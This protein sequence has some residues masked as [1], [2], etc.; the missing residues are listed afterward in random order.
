MFKQ[1]DYSDLINKNKYQVFLFKSKAFF[2][3]SFAIHPWFVLVKKGEISRWEFCHMKN[4]NN[5]I[6]WGHIYKNWKPTFQGIGFFPY[7]LGKIYNKSNL[8][9]KIEGDEARKMIDFIE[10][11]SNTYKYCNEY[12]LW[13]PNSNTYIQWIL[14]NFPESGLELPDNAYGKNYK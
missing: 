6:H 4:F 7:G 9:G 1:K 10:N 2:P 8:I 12:H 11:S 5:A 13:G 14:N 3:F